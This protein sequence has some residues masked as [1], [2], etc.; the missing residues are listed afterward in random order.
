[1]EPSMTRILGSIL[2]KA[3]ATIVIAIIVVSFLP[4]L[5]LYRID[6]A[7]A[8]PISKPENIIGVWANDRY[9]D[10]IIYKYSGK[11]GFNSNHAGFGDIVDLTYRD[12]GLYELQFTKKERKCS[13]IIYTDKS[14]RLFLYRQFYWS[15]SEM[16]EKLT[17]IT[18]STTCEYL[19]RRPFYKYKKL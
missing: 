18:W 8:R 11:Y 1:M 14:D 19:T 2:Y 6:F 15:F 13:V 9:D 4:D 16:V 7:S 3:S 17:P 10:I 12:E 5:L